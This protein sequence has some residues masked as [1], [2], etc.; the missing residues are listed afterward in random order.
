M[1]N[2]FITKKVWKKPEEGKHTAVLRSY[3][4]VEYK[5]TAT[6]EAG[7]YLECEFLLDGKRE[8]KKNLFEQD[9]RIMASAL[10]SNHFEEGM[11]LVDIL[12][13]WIADK[14]EVD[15][16]IKFNSNNGTE[17]TNFYWYEPAENTTADITTFENA[18]IMNPDLP[19]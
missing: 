13:K 7:D 11:S 9:V 18:E 10:V 17:Y 16:W 5:A 8:I 6:R 15:L 1:I 12:N 4:V 14:T 3:T 2:D 19:L